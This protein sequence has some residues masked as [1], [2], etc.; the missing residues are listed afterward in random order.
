MSVPFQFKPLRTTNSKRLKLA[1]EVR[2]KFFHDLFRHLYRNDI[3]TGEEY[4]QLKDSIKDIPEIIDNA[5]DRDTATA[6]SPS[7]TVQSF[8]GRPL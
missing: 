1:T 2:L 4:R 8:Q 5:L 3:I 6:G 7:G